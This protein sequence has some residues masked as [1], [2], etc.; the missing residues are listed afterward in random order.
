[1]MCLPRRT[2]QHFGARGRT[3]PG[4]M[5]TAEL[6]IDHLSRPGIDADIDL[7]EGAALRWTGMDPASG[8]FSKGTPGTACLDGPFHGPGHEEAWG[9]FD[10][11]A[12]VRGRG[13]RRDAVVPEAA[14]RWSVRS[15]SGTDMRRN[16]EGFA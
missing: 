5:G 4:L 1:M 6:C 10:T 12:Y 9:T 16:S 15:F 14:V 13:V 11:G 3:L 8:S 7:A 2:A